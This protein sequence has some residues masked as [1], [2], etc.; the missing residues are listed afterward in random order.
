[1][2]VLGLNYK[3]GDAS[4]CII[5]NG[6]LLFAAEE[7]RFTKIK[8][9]SQFPIN[10]IKFCLTSSDTK[11]EDIDYIATNSDP[12]YNFLN[13]VVFFSKNILNKNLYKYIFSSI[14]KKNY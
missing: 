4:A 12:K 8:N 11:I 7:E 2:I 10:A 14:F 13:K 5:K 9:C 6:K 3:H 1:M